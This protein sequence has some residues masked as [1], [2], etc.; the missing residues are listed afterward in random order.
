MSR[1][2][3]RESFFII[4]AAIESIKLTFPMKR[5]LFFIL[6]L[7]G[8]SV[9]ISAQTYQELSERALDRVEADEPDQAEELF[10]QALKLEPTNPRNALI[11]SNIGMIQHR[12]R[13]YDDAIES[14]T[15]ALN[16]APKAVPILLNRAAVYMELGKTDHA[17][18][19]YCQVLDG[20]KVNAEALLMRAY[21]YTIRRDYKAAR[22]D[23]DC[24]LGIDP[25]NYNARLGLA[26]LNQKEKKFNAAVGLI[27]KLIAEHPGDA[28]LYVARAGL[29]VDMEH[30]D[31]ALIDLEEAIRLDADAPDAFILR[32][33]IYLSQKKKA[34]AKQD[35]EKAIRLGVPQSDLRVQIQQCR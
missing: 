3:F 4:F 7:C 34:L 35:F 14:F 1:L 17:Y 28:V 19:D 23:Y 31:L 9:L 13:E 10:R 11:F 24:L 29:E 32:G 16:I 21:I 22:M 8:T 18:T 25:A 27:S 26:T 20:D 2:R 30:I 12:K 15:Y 33:E 5:F 6:V